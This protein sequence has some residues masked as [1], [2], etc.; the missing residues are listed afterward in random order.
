MDIQA[1]VNKREE[2]G[3]S[4]RSIYQLFQVLKPILQFAI[5]DERIRR[6]PADGIT[7]PNFAMVERHPLDIEKGLI[8][9]R[10]SKIPAGIRSMPLS[11]EEVGQ[12]ND[13]II[14]SW[15]QLSHVS[16]PLFTSPNGH[17]IQ[18]SNYMKRK[19]KPAYEI[20]GL[21]DIH[22]HDLR[23]NSSTTLHPVQKPRRR[24]LVQ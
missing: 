5:R 10:K 22:F 19:F 3:L 4:P 14:A 23:G 8:F 13:Y 11:V 16:E 15:R 24:Q 12:P 21:A 20:A 7:K 17:R 18:Y 2:L 9:V 6:N 1:L